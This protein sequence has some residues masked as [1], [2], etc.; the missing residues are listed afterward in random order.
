MSANQSRRKRIE[1]QDPL[2]KFTSWIA[3]AS[4][5]HAP[6]AGEWRARK[7]IAAKDGHKREVLDLRSFLG[8]RSRTDEE[9]KSKMRPAAAADEKREKRPSSEAEQAASKREDD[10][11]DDDDHAD[12]EKVGNEDGK[13]E[14]GKMS[15][16]RLPKEGSKAPSRKNSDEDLCYGEDVQNVE[17][18]ETVG[19]TVE[20][21]PKPAGGGRE[22]TED[23]GAKRQSASPLLQTCVGCANTCDRSPA[24]TKKEKSTTDGVL[25]GLT[26]EEAAG[27]GSNLVMSGALQD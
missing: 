21:A 2:P 13:Q 9:M 27:D 1:D 20:D 8:F 14:G 25:S 23:Q 26:V 5:G 24:P 12:G 18:E 6:T 3:G 22:C 17:P 7:P 16:E 11:K 19:G 15:E 4:L 10:E